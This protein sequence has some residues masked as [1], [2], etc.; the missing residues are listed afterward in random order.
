MHKFLL[1]QVRTTSG[2]LQQNVYETILHIVIN[3]TQATA[4]QQ[5]DYASA[6]QDITNVNNN[7]FI[8]KFLSLK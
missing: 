1:L 6:S 3:T 2:S 4:E 7:K 8:N 5:W